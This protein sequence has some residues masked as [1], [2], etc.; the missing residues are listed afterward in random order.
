MPELTGGQALVEALKVHGVDTIFGLP[1][2]QLD[3]AFDALWAEQHNI[4]VVHARHE[5]ATASMADGYARSTG[6][7]RRARV[8][9]PGVLNATAALSTAYA[10]NS[11]VSC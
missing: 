4:R 8:P 2:I 10:C 6:K 11:P 1:G 9:G 3:W 5:Q 7:R